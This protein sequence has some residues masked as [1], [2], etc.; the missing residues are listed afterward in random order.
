MADKT[1]E[2]KEVVQFSKQGHVGLITLNRPGAMNS[3]NGALC[4][5]LTEI[6]EAIERDDDI[7]VAVITGAGGKAFCAGIDLTERK[8]MSDEDVSALR[9]FVK[10]GRASCRERV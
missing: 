10:I 4:S 3:L 5:K 9:K 8:G 1:P 7:R 6:I 2:D